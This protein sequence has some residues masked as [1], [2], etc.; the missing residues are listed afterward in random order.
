M[1][2]YDY[3]LAFNPA[4]ARL[5]LAEKQIPYVKRHVDL[6][7]G[8]SLSPEFLKLQPGGTVPVL[9]DE[10]QVRCL[11]ARGPCLRGHAA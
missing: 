11:C 2:L 5:M 9:D 1:I 10:G 6:F 4:K 3:A 7:T 8:Q